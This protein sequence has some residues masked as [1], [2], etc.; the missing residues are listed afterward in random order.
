[1]ERILEAFACGRISIEPS[2]FEQYFRY[3]KDDLTIQK[4]DLLT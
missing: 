2:F 3:G 4:E 1:M